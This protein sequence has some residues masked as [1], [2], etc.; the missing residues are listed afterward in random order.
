MDI[1]G[2]DPMDILEL[3]AALAD[4]QTVADKADATQDEVDEAVAALQAVVEE[5]KK[6]VVT[7]TETPTKVDKA[8][9]EAAVAEANAL[10]PYA[11]ADFTAVLDA[12]NAAFDV[13]DKADATQ[14]EVD[15]ALE[16]L[17]AA[18]AALTPATTPTE[19][20]TTTPEVTPL[21][22]GVVMGVRLLDGTD[23]PVKENGTKEFYMQRSLKWCT[24]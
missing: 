21:P 2:V 18:V 3:M 11:Y 14:A 8:A 13:I 22:E 12:I 10:D 24:H 1:T 19:E 20:P 9:L 6:P 17:E 7:P 5:L 16:A 4:A 15:A 23:L